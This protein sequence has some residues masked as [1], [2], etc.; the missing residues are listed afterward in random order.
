MKLACSSSKLSNRLYTLTLLK[1][2]VQIHIMG[3]LGCKYICGMLTI[4][5]TH[6]I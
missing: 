6:K 2:W 5:V 1:I 3:A 4:N